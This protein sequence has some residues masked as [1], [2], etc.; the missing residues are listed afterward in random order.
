MSSLSPKQSLP[1]DPPAD[2][3]ADLLADA[4]ATAHI[5]LRNPPLIEEWREAFF[6]LFQDL[7]LDWE[8]FQTPW[9]Y[10]DNI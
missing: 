7:E 9:P 8:Q 1:A 10:I 5:L 2:L 3:L 6:F 4:A